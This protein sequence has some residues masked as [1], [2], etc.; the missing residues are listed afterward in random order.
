M[1][2]P[3]PYIPSLLLLLLLLAATACEQVSDYDGPLP[4]LKLVVFSFIEPDSTIRVQVGA[5]RYFDGVAT[6]PE[7]VS[8]EVFINGEKAGDLE[9]DAI[10][11][12]RMPVRPRAGDRVRIAVRA[13][14]LPEVSGETTLPGLPPVVSVDTVQVTSATGKLQQINYTL[15][16][17]GGEGERRYYRLL[18]RT[19][20]YE[21]VGEAIYNRYTYYDFNPE[22][23]PLLVGGG[24]NWLDDSESNTYAI[25]TNE[26]FEGGEYVMR[27]SARAENSTE[28]AYE[29]NGELIVQRRV[30]KQEVKLVAL[31][32]DSYLY[33]KSVTLALR[34]Q[35]AVIE[36]VQV[37]S[38]VNGGVGIV[39]YAYPALFSY[40]M[41]IVD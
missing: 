29:Q 10:D 3:L 38:N 13:R 7:A 17:P 37:H 14:S 20:I 4:D 12:Y 30:V 1:K 5:T 19:T 15:R 21:Q 32:S 22:N 18:I 26:S 9:Y 24:N 39:G 8:G 23:D 33:L 35:G 36:P 34:D 11:G 27:V 28:V 40:E 41:P 31:D 2:W 6:L 16:I 25:F